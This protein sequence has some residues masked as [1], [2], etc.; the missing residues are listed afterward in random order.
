MNSC[1]FVDDYKDCGV[2]CVHLQVGR[3]HN[4]LRSAGLLGGQQRSAQ[5][6]ATV[7]GRDLEAGAAGCSVAML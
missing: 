1:R 4:L 2:A 6:S 7:L 5:H 3:F